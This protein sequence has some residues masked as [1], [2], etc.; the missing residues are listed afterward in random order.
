MM[1]VVAG[2]YLEKE[3]ETWKLLPELT[4]LGVAGEHLELEIGM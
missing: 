1:V 4:V 2:E 3:M